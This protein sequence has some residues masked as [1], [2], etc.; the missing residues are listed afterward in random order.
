M[1][2]PTVTTVDNNKFHKKQRMSASPRR[3]KNKSIPSLG[4]TTLTSNSVLETEG[5]PH[6]V[7][8]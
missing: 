4:G 3:S 8:R 7:E 5:G 2:D 6:E 1:M